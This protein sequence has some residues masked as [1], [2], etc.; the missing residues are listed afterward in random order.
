[1]RNIKF[2]EKFFFLRIKKNLKEVKREG[3]VSEFN[4]HGCLSGRSGNVRPFVMRQSWDNHETMS[5]D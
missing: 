2:K 5:W 3:D 4:I 1:M